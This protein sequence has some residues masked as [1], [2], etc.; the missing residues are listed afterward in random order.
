MKIIKP[1][2]QG[3]QRIESMRNRNRNRNTKAHNNQNAQD[4]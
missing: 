4:W 1:Q 3:V 2:V